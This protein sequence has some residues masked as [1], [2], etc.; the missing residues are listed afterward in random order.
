MFFNIVLK[1]AIKLHSDTASELA[2]VQL[3]A[4]LIN[5]VPLAFGS[6][7]TL[8][9][10]V[11]ISV[12]LYLNKKFRKSKKLEINSNPNEEKTSLLNRV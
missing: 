8:L 5:I 4:D 11:F 1:K 9:I 12:K 10:V 3:I 6:L 7:G 2:T